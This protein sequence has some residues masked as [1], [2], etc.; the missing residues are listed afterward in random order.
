MPIIST[1]WGTLSSVNSGERRLPAC[2]A[3]QPAE[4]IRLCASNGLERFI[5]RIAVV[6]AGKLPA[7][8]GWQPAL[9]RN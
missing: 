2:C 3:R 9:P 4:H 6:V 8:A 5:A 7:A 1:Y